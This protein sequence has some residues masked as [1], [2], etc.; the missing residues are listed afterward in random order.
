[1]GFLC[2]YDFYFFK[3]FFFMWTIC[4]VYLICYSTASVLRFV[5]WPR[6]MWDLNSPSHTPQHWKAKSQ[7]LDHQG[8]PCP[9]RFPPLTR[10]YGNRATLTTSLPLNCLPK[11]SVSKYSLTRK[12]S[13]QSFQYGFAGCTIQPK[14]TVTS[15]PFFVQMYLFIHKKMLFPLLNGILIVISCSA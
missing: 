7:P 11:S 8:S 10:T 14:P 12:D 1:M 4:K 2:V 3:N 6:G 13:E 15:S 9:C 5:F